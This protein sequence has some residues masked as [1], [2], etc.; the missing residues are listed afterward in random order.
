M[1]SFETISLDDYKKLVDNQKKIFDLTENFTTPEILNKYRHSDK[2]IE[3]KILKNEKM[4]EKYDNLDKIINKN[5][6]KIKEKSVKNITNNYYSNDNDEDE[7]YIP[8]INE[9]MDVVDIADLYEQEYKFD[10]DESILN[11][12]SKIYEKHDIKYKPRNNSKFNRV[13]YLLQKL[14]ENDDIDRSLYNHFQTSLSERNKLYH[15]IPTYEDEQIGSSINYIMINK[16][17]LD[18]N[19]FR[20]RY[21]NNRKLTNNLLKHDYKISK[22]W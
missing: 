5:I 18:K 11:S 21:L 10:N 1:T 15:K 2:N 19:I 20:V 17:D 6:D 4:K 13:K 14:K 16:K 9:N 12:F 3:D 7:K 22:K 8:F